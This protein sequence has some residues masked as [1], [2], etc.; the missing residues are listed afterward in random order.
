MIKDQKLLK[1]TALGLEVGK[2]L[3]TGTFSYEVIILQQFS[4]QS[5]ISSTVLELQTGVT[6]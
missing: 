4:W 1:L 3:Q 6:W 2:E 5:L